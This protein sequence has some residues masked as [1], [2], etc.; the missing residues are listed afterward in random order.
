MKCFKQ[1]FIQQD[2]AFV[3]KT[4]KVNFASALPQSSFV[5]LDKL[6]NLSQSQ[7]SH[8]SNGTVRSNIIPW[9][10]PI[11][12][13]GRVKADLIFVA[14]EVGVISPFTSEKMEALRDSLSRVTCLTD[15]HQI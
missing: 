7:C 8:L 4:L 2:H 10:V 11:T 12:A 5:T 14:N 9:K 15:V 13:L 3:D 6:C 1:V